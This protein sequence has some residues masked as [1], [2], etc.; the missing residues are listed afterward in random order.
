MI[1]VGAGLI[2]TESA[3]TLAEAGHSVTLVDIL[4]R[5]LDRLHDPLPNLGRETLGELGVS[6]HGEL[7]IESAT[8]YSRR[9]RPRTE[10]SRPT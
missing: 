8:A 10:H 9:R 2:G 3:A 7:V 1:V 6:F 4:E 5:P